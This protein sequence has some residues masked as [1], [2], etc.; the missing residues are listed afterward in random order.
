MHLTTDNVYAKI[1]FNIIL[2]KGEENAY[3]EVCIHNQSGKKYSLSDWSNQHVFLP[4]GF[5]AALSSLLV[6]DDAL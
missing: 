6:I 2:R 1:F 4:C 5:C 3:K